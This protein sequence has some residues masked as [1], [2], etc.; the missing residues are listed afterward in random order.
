MIR[1]VA[2]TEVPISPLSLERFDPLIGP[3]EAEPVHRAIDEAQR[4]FAGRTVWNVNSTA[5]GGGVAELL[6][7]L[8]AYVRGCG[9][10]ARWLVIQGDPEFFRITKR[11]HNHLHGSAGDGG[12]LGD[13][14]H[15]H[16]MAV[17]ESNAVLLRER[18]RRNDIVILHDPQTAGLI[19]SM[20]DA[21]ALV[22]WR[23]HVG[24]DVP[25][26]T[27]RQAWDFLRPH[28]LAADATVFSHAAF[29]W[30]GLDAKRTWVIPPSIDPFSAKNCELEPGQVVG[31]LDAGGI[32]ADGGALSVFRRPDGS[33]G[34]IE[35]R[36]RMVPTTPVAGDARIVLQVSRWDRLKDPLGVMAG[37]ADH[38]ALQCDADLVLAGP[39]VDAVS[40]DP[41]G[42]EVLAEVTAA[43]DRLPSNVADRCHLA[44][45]PMADLEENAV[46]VNA[47]QRRATVVVQKSLA[48]GFGL[49]VSEAMWKARPVVASRVGGIQDQ[50]ED[51]VSGRLLDDPHDLAGFGSIVRSLLDDPDRAWAMGERAR[52]RVRDNFLGPHHLRR[53]LDL[54]RSLG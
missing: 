54:L 17:L 35:H 15:T 12:P 41:E 26:D 43:R 7:S 30:E 44:C 14:E 20:C 31:I 3:G 1:S 21:G 16:Y 27:V 19:E 4:E 23:C 47:L 8:L 38:V 22:L 34:R 46:I 9:V 13:A 29:V 45:L 28:V 40:D 11:L 32:I 10:D 24:V 5:R 51:G 37:F 33:P 2:L 25:N 49:T 48:E 36:A 39:D 42:V 18:V 53:Y 50:I 6:A 52:L